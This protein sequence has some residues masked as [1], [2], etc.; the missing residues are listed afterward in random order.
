MYI[1][2]LQGGNYMKTK[3]KNDMNTKRSGSCQNRKNS[4]NGGN[5]EAI[6]RK[7][8]AVGGKIESFFNKDSVHLNLI[9]LRNNKYPD[10]KEIIRRRPEI[11]EIQNAKY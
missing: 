4:V 8:R 1:I 3:D 7:V 9:N 6:M 11:K 2:F 5:K 10:G